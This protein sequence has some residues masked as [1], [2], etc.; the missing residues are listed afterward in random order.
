VKDAYEATIAVI[1]A[2]SK[3]NASLFVVSTHIIEA[4]E[5]IGSTCSNAQFLYMPT[6]MK[7]NVPVYSYKI[8]PGI[9]NDRHGMII[10][11]KE[12]IL[13]LLRGTKKNQHA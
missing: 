6:S 9:T 2:F 11:Q 1:E 12:G 7:E 4:G 8:Q 5:V 10:I 13:D 3:K